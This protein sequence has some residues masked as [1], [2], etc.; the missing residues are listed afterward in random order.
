MESL[1]NQFF[2]LKKWVTATFL[3]WLIGFTLIVVLAV[4][5]DTIGIGNVQFFVGTGMGLGVGFMQWRILKRFFNGDKKW[6][7]YAVLG[8]TIPFLFFDIISLLFSYSSGSYFIPLSTGLG[9]LIAGLLQFR[10][11]RT[12]YPKAKFWIYASFL[13]WVSAALTVVIMDFISLLNIANWIG[14]SINITLILGG[15]VVLGL[16]TGLFLRNILRERPSLSD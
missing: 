3:G 11:L 5:L 6:I 15:G 9:G 16:I 14:F 1:E 7:W 10:I 12:Y 8:L 2:T 13:G 4:I